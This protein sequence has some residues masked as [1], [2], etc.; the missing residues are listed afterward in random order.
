MRWS[1]ASEDEDGFIIL[2]TEVNG[3][4]WDEVGR[5][6]ANTINFHDR[7][8][9]QGVNYIYK[10]RSYKMNNDRMI[11]VLSG[12]SNSITPHS[13]QQDYQNDN[14]WDDTRDDNSDTENRYTGSTSEDFYYR[15]FRRSRG[16]GS[17]MN[18][19]HRYN[20]DV[21]NDSTSE[22][23][24]YRNF[25]RSRGNGS[26]T[27]DRYTDSTSDDFYARNFPRLRRN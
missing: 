20:N 19:D 4:R 1:D 2:R 24:Y 11:S 21:D 27:E 3:G 18:N 22:D 6:E 16:N 13:V 15:N 7:N 26:D 17:N 23:F 5:V 10:V 12:T 8:V 25:R 14:N 9:D